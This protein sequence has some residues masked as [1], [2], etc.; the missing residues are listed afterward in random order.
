M[1]AQQPAAAPSIWSTEGAARLGQG[2]TMATSHDDGSIDHGVTQAPYERRFSPY[3]FNGGTCL[4]IAGKDFA[5]VAG[6]TRL[7]TGYEILSRNVPKLCK[8]T[9]KTVLASAGCLTDVRT[10]QQVLDMRLRMYEHDNGKEISTP[11]VA[12]LLGNTLYYRRFFPYYAFNVLA[13]VDDEGKGCVF[14]YD[15]VGSHERVEYSASGSGQAFVIPLL[16]NIVGFKNRQDS[17]PE[18]TAEQVVAICKDAFLTA[19]ERDIYTGDAVMI[20]VITSKGVT[21][22]TFHLKKD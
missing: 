22:E 15:A 10:L 2:V 19:G 6:D 11:A 7:S 12:Q 18:Y 8:L 13:G 3:D 21:T 20:S 14:S 17:K 9:S 5:V 16:D 1:K 4:A